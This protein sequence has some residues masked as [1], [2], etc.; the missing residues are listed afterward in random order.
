MSA[1]IVRQDGGDE[2]TAALRAALIWKSLNGQLPLA[3]YEESRLSGI[4]S[5]SYRG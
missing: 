4:V 2:E 5:N 1:D 3:T